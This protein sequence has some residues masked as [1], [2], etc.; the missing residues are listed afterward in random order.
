MRLFPKFGDSLGEARH[1]HLPGPAHSA[2]APPTPLRPR[3]SCRSVTH[4]GAAWRRWTFPAGWL[5][6]TCSCRNA[7]RSRWR[8]EASSGCAPSA[9]SG[10]RPCHCSACR[11]SG[12]GTR[13]QD[14]GPGPSPGGK[15]SPLTVRLPDSLET[16]HSVSYPSDPWISGHSHRRPSP[17]S[18]APQGHWTLSVCT[19]D[20]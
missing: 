19:S 20:H 4:A 2:P 6:D 11:G 15:P 5:R 7:G 9:P 10:P 1:L 14:P 18:P 13:P 17:G 12:S 8:R 16:L 3:P